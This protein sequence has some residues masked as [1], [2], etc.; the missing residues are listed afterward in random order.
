MQKCKKQTKKT[1]WLKLLSLGVAVLGLY[2]A[3]QCLADN[4]PNNI[5]DVAT[6]ITSAFKSVGELMIATAYLAGIGFVIAAIFKF[7]QHRDNPTQIPIGTPIALLVIGI[8]LVFLPGIIGPTGSTIFGGSQNNFAGGFR[9][10]GANNI[11]GGAG[12]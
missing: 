2:V 3:T 5:A 11:P 4:G 1:N 8:F 7:K 10:T 9:G 12:S 6:N